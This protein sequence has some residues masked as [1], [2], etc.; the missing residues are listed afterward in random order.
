MI[1]LTDSSVKISG[2]GIEKKGGRRK[3]RRGGHCAPSFAAW[4]LFA[5]FL[6]RARTP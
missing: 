4:G 2:Y 3:R 6:F 1:Q 5:G